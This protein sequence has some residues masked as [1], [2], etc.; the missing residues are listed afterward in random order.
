[1][2]LPAE[3]ADLSRRHLDLADEPAPELVSG[4]YLTGSV[5]LADFCPAVSDVDFVAVVQRVPTDT[6]PSTFGLG[7]AG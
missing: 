3:V 5:A 2:H 4:L 1:M 6:S 7:R